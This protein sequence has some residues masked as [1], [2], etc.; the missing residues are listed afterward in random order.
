MSSAVKQSDGNIYIS[1]A[2]NM[3]HSLKR[4]A[5]CNWH[6][7]TATLLY[8]KRHQCRYWLFMLWW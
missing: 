3:M 6:D 8:S 5:S 2:L 1:P 4:S 7:V